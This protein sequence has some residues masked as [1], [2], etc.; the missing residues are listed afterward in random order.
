MK[1]RIFLASLLFSFA[2][3]IAILLFFI[4]Q[5][6]EEAQDTVL[7]NEAV[8]TVQNDWHTIKNHKNKT[9]LDYVVIDTNERVLFRTKAGL[10][11][12]INKAIRHRDTILDI[13]ADGLVAGKI[14][15]ANDRMQSFERQKKTMVLFLSAVILIQCIFCVGYFCY[16]EHYIIKPFYKLKGFA[17]RV[18]G[19]NF[20]IPLMMD[21]QNL[22]GAFTESFDIMRSELKRARIAEAKANADK[23][24]LVAKLSHDIKTPVASIKAAS[25]VGAALTDNEKS[26]DNYT[27]IIR[28]ADQINTLITNLFSASLEELRQLSV[29]PE[30]IE[31]KELRILLEN[32]DYFHRSTIPDIPGCILYLDRL[33][34]QQVFDNIFANSY[35]YADT[36]IDVAVQRDKRYLSVVMEDYGGGVRIE[37]L[38]LLKEKYKRGSNIKD[39]EGAGLGLYISDYFMKEM[40][41]KLIVENGDHGL[42]VTVMLALGGGI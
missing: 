29:T 22:F 28:K 8:Q 36:R 11:E 25:E 4:V 19:G 6:T 27:Q 23:K 40:H 30:E 37:E 35:K 16:L 1:K 33:R 3:E 39:K 26:K 21:R 14:I 17:M 13:E 7:V 42:K 18:A 2:I 38:A 31:S 32:S 15:V 9:S 12:N 10:S 41:G 24:E 34:L 5:N 20:D